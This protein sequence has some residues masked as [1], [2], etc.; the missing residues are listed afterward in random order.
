MGKVLLQFSVLV[1]IFLA[2]FLGLSRV[3]FMKHLHLDGISQKTEKKIGDL[4][5]DGIRKS[6]KEINDDKV[7]DA[8][9]KIKNRLCVNNGIAPDDISIHLVQN[10]EVNAFAIPGHHIIIYTGLIEHCDSA[11]ELCGV[12]GHEMGHIRLNHVMKRL[13][14]E[15]GLGLLATVAS[16]GNS[17]VIGQIIKMLSSTAFERKQESEADAISVKYMQNARVDPNGFAA[18]MQKLA[19]MHPGTPSAM[20]W[21]ST[22]PDSKKRAETILSLINTNQHNYKPLLDDDEWQVIKYASESD[23]E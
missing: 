7:Q 8:L 19:D 1:I 10:K 20:E 14:N 18:I 2:V 21:I 9:N 16:N 12:I 4:L 23:S 3:N 15:L 11:T 17:A 22:H 5:M 13:V 6:N